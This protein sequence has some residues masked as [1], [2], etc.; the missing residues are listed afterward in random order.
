MAVQLCGE[1]G[2]AA[3]RP[4]LTRLLSDAATPVPLRKA[5]E[6]SLRALDGKVVA[7]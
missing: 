3:S 2:I 7:Q 6:W 4:L 1:R 5:A